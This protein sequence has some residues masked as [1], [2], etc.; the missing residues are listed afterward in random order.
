MINQSINSHANILC[1]S[2]CSKSYK[3][4]T[5]LDKHIILCEIIKNPNRR[6][7]QIEDDDIPSQ[8]RMYQ[9]LLELGY[10]YNLLEE[11]VNNL[12]K[13]VVKKKK[14]INALEWLNIN[15][16]PDIIFNDIITTIQIETSD[17][18][19]FMDNLN[20]F[21]DTICR[22][23][24]RNIFVFNSE[25]QS[26]LP[27]CAFSQ[28]NGVFYIYDKINSEES[29]KWLELNR[30]KFVKFLNSI[31]KKIWKN[32]S[33]W[34]KN[35]SSEIQKNDSLQVQYDKTMSKLMSIDFNND[36]T[37]NKIKNI[38]Y[39][40]MKIDITTIIEYEFED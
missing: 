39:N 23:F 11:K 15:V 27:L 30:E 37:F 26:K 18:E 25:T 28:K 16:K 22:I 36:A 17:I 14:T 13:W 19:Y 33:E 38:M 8:T 20:S 24:E 21:N 35:N 4:K 10:K 9:M 40:K 29:Y 6:K 32:L 7:I 3:T 12:N 2:Y 31:Y 34:K 1:C 5:R